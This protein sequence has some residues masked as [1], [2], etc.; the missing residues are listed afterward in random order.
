M[1]Q[2][3]IAPLVPHQ[4]VLSLLSYE[5]LSK[6]PL[7]FKSFIDLHYKNLMKFTIK[8]WQKDMKTC[9]R[10]F[11]KKKKQWRKK[12]SGGRRFHTRC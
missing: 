9:D 11:I 4:P 10:A 2:I 5:R 8:I 12:I 3:T 1:Q 7:L 6:K